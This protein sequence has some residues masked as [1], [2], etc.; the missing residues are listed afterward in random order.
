MNTTKE[1]ITYIQFLEI[2]H[3]LDIRVGVVYDAKRIPKS[4]K[5][6]ELQVSFGDNHTRTVVTNLGSKFEP[7]K[8]IGVTFP[9][10]MNL[11]HSK[12]MGVTSEAM[13]LVGETPNGEIELSNYTTGSKLI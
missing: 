6:L 10:V 11:V 7:E 5:L 13:I 3:K 4:D 9:F 12:M 8:F 1:E 2:E